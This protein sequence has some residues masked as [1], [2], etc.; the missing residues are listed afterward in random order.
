MFNIE[1]IVK[2]AFKKIKN[3]G[4]FVNKLW[5]NVKCIYPKKI[6]IIITL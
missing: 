3:N 1:I 4:E 5:I 6:S 2:I